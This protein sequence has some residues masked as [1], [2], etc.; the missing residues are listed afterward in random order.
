METWSHFSFVDVKIFLLI[1]VQGLFLH[2]PEASPVFSVRAGHRSGGF[3][4]TSGPH[5]AED[6]PAVPRLWRHCS[7]RAPLQVADIAYLLLF[8][9]IRG[10]LE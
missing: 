3:N 2:F 6:Q 8:K 4:L 1:F 5:R 9:Q 7:T 10:V